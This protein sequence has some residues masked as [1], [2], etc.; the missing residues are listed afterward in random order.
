MDL[1]E[2]EIRATLLEELIEFN[3]REAREM[4]HTVYIAGAHYTY[5]D[6]M[7]GHRFAT[8]DLEHFHRGLL[9]YKESSRRLRAL[10]ERIELEMNEKY[11]EKAPIKDT[12]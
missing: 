11:P 3:I 5:L 7:R 10:R 1:R 12:E 2:I 4:E 8:G 6:K 9:M